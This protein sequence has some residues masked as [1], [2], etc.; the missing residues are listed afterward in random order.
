MYR[1]LIIGLLS[2]H[3]VSYCQAC[4]GCAAAACT[5]EEE[6][7]AKKKESSQEKKQRETAEAVWAR[8]VE[9]V[10]L[11]PGKDWPEKL[12]TTI[13][14]EVV[15]TIDLG[16]RS[17]KLNAVASLLRDEKKE[18]VKRNGKN[19]PHVEITYGYIDL[20]GNDENGIA[21]VL[22]HEL[23]HHA[24]G[25][26]LR[27]REDVPP[28]LEAAASHRREADAD[29]YG[30][31]LMLEAGYS[32]RKGIRAEWTGLEARG[33]TY[34]AV[35]GTCVSHPGDS[36]RAARVLGVLDKGE[37]K[38]WQSMAE[39]DNGATF[40][41]IENFAA[42]EACF[43]R[44]TKEFPSCPEA[45]AN[46]GVA[47]LMLFCQKLTAKEIQS[48]GIGHFLGTTH[49]P[50]APSLLRGDSQ[51]LWDSAEEALKKARD[52]MP[53]SPLILTNLGLAYLLNP[54]GKD[55]EKATEN[56]TEAE[57]ALG[58]A[59]NLSPRLRMVLLVNFGV[60]ALAQG[61]RARGRKYL[62]QA[63][64]LAEKAYG[65]RDRWPLAVRG[66]IAFNSAALLTPSDAE[67]ATT[68]Y[69]EYLQSAPRSS[70]WWPVAYDRYQSLCKDQN[71]KPLDKTALGEK[72]APLRKQVVVTLPGG[73][74]LHIGESMKKVK[75]KLGEPTSERTE[76]GSVSRRSYAKAGIDVLAD[77]D[78]V[79][80]IEIVS[81]KVQG[82]DIREAGVTGKKLGELKVGMS[83]KEIEA[84]LGGGD[85]AP[86]FFF[87]REYPYYPELS[88]AINYNDSDEVV[89]L[90]IGNLEAGFLGE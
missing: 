65:N 12:D 27:K 63:V 49:Y 56:F 37:E 59:A 28:A 48:L 11:E 23:G 25:H 46:L 14:F 8:L 7:P 51:K 40:L 1:I 16:G 24:L 76:R 26:T 30:G 43:N 74:T 33:H 31:R 69:V 42:A 21:L 20:V 19:V 3:S 47:R 72:K 84:K 58:S 35:K 82:I 71:R 18:E 77:S 41:A 38:L 57:K 9:K 4:D 89:G 81:P 22:A 75:E 83:R 5:M 67:Q 90:V 2:L 68:L 64:S 34:A 70:A 45:W 62:D 10:K 66:A 50:S 87:K 78:E 6:K 36:D 15:E 55:V 88:V 61:E 52:L 44:V 17:T 60:N 86:A 53:K 39:F 85:T 32:L 54:A 79:F 73:E 80:V 13:V 29:L